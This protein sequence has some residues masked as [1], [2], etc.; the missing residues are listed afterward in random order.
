MALSNRRDF[1]QVFGLRQVILLDLAGCFQRQRKKNWCAVYC[2]I[3]E[4]SN[5]IIFRTGTVINNFLKYQIL[6][7]SIV[8]SSTMRDSDHLVTISGTIGVKLL[9][10]K[11]RDV[12]LH[13]CTMQNQGHPQW[14]F[15]QKRLPNNWCICN[16]EPLKYSLLQSHLGVTINP[17]ET[18][19]SSLLS[20]SH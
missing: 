17:L 11:Q 9:L 14:S 3:F 12:S 4:C 2:T 13:Q 1:M 5:I 10:H 18:V 15:C 19:L 8:R 7:N 16:I 6:H 20:V